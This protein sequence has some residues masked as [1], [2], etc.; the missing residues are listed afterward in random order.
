MQT[1]VG[2]AQKLITN[3]INTATLTTNIRTHTHNATPHNWEIGLE[4][5]DRNNN[6]LQ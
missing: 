3:T 2:L 1:G 4:K 6:D 5:T